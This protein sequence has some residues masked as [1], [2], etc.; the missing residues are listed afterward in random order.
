MRLAALLHDLG[1]PIAGDRDHAEVGAELAG[2]ILGRLRYPTR[3]RAHTVRLVRRHAFSLA[4]E[5]DALRA[6][7]FLAEHGLALARDLLALKHADLSAKNVQPWEH[8]ALVRLQELV[9]R[10]RVNPFR[11]TDLAVDGS[12]L[13]GLGFSEGPALGRTLERLLAEVIEDP[14]LNRREWLLE[15]ARRELE[16][17]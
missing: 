9:E 14:A 3:L 5:V 6:R 13:I 2:R 15:Q 12:D 4:G 17:A 1:K 7:R 10:E 11:I 8:E 16:P